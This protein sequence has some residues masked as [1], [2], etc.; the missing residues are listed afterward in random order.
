[1]DEADD[2]EWDKTKETSN[3]AKHGLSLKLA[4]EL[5]ISDLWIEFE[6]KES[7]TDPSRTIAIW[8]RSRPSANMRL[9]AKRSKAACYFA[10]ACKS[11]R[12]SCLRR[13]RSLKPLKL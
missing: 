1:M 12:T 5:F 13:S 6:G 2:F 4:A 10:S 8:S 3:V 7:R 11:E 9:H